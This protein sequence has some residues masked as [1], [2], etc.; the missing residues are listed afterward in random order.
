MSVLEKLNI[1]IVGACGKGTG[2]R[3]RAVLNAAC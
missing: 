3:G 2:F 1:D